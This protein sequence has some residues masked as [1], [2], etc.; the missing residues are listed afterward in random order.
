MLGSGSIR[1]EVE[2]L[3]FFSVLVRRVAETCMATT[4][5]GLGIG[6]KTVDGTT[7][8]FQGVDDLLLCQ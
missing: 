2:V 7:D 4:L 1:A 3:L 6:I 8:A 5:A